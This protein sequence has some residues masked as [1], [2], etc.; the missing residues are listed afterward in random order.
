MHVHAPPA[1]GP[2]LPAG[3]GCPASTWPG[4]THRCS[5]P[6]PL[7]QAPSVLVWNFP[8]TAQCPV[9]SD[10]DSLPGDALAWGQLTPQAMCFTLNSGA[11][12]LGQAA[13]PSLTG[14]GDSDT[15]TD[16]PGTYVDS[17]DP[18]AC[19]QGCVSRVTVS[20]VPCC[21]LMAMAHPTT[22]PGGQWAH[23]TAVLA[24]HAGTLRSREAGGLEVTRPGVS[25]PGWPGSP[26]SPC[27]RAQG[28]I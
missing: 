9:A 8:G 6:P 26:C 13:H 23:L 11:P 20:G 28:H 19:G 25:Q 3:G 7:P 22:V 5:R 14:V 10:P 17:P 18:T 16:R 1:S 24:V 2:S 4:P 12:L 27:G 21:P 15:L